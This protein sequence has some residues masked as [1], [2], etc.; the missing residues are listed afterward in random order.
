MD[1]DKRK[2]NMFHGNIQTKNIY[3]DSNNTAKLVDFGQVKFQVVE[4]VAADRQYSVPEPILK[5]TAN[6]SMDA[7]WY[8]C[9]QIIS[10][11]IN[12]RAESMCT[13]LV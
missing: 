7:L 6:H 11:A 13:L 8:T 3:L 10:G 1:A 5:T 12:Y 2:Y 4:G 9:P